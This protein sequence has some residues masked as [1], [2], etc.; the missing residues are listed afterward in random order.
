[1]CNI[2]LVIYIHICTV[3]ANETMPKWFPVMLVAF[4][5]INLKHCWK[6]PVKMSFYFI[7]LTNVILMGD[8]C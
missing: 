7:S 8:C 2:I 5:K 3:Q 1:M 6:T 4:Q